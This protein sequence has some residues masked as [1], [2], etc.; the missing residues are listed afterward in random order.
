MELEYRAATFEYRRKKNELRGLALPFGVETLLGQGFRE[1]FLPGAFPELSDAILYLR[2]GGPSLARVP[3]SLAIEAR[4]D[5][6]HILATLPNTAPANEAKELIGNGTL[7]G[8]SVEFRALEDEFQAD[9]LRVIARAELSGI[10]IV[11]RA[12]Y[13]AT[14]VDVRAW[15]AK[16]QRRIPLWVC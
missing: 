2:H 16:K 8:L 7:Q 5:G 13:A 3:K 6:L 11:E 15:Q 10:A 14:S 1:K 12:A 4:E 9:G